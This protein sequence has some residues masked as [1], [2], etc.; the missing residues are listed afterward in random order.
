M[1][2]FKKSGRFNF[3]ILLVKILTESMKLQEIPVLNMC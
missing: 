1:K 2:I 3:L